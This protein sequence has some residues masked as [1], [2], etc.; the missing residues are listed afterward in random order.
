MN[1]QTFDQHWF[2]LKSEICKR[3]GQFTEREFATVCGSAEELIAII[4][5]KTGEARRQ[6]E[7]YLNSISPDHDFAGSMRKIAVHYA[8]G[9]R[10]NV[11][12]FAR[13]ASA[14]TKTGYLETQR[15]ARQNPVQTLAIVFGAGLVAGIVGGMLARSK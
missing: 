15:L 1:Q 11:Q 8:G 5:Q 7:D 9:A 14:Q 12:Q 4:E 13:R 10:E 3:W 2:E 6:I